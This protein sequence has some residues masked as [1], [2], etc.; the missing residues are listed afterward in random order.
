M[1]PAASTS[2][3]GPPG[4]AREG[5]PFRRPARTT[6]PL[7]V[8]TMSWSALARNRLDA[9]QAIVGTIAKHAGMPGQGQL[10]PIQDIADG[11][12]GREYSAAPEKWPL[13]QSTEGESVHLVA[14]SWPYPCTWSSRGQVQLI[15]GE[16]SDIALGR[17]HA[18]GAFQGGQGFR[19]F[20]A[21]RRTG[22]TPCPAAPPG[23][24]ERAEGG[25]TAGRPGP[26]RPPG[27]G[28]SNV[29]RT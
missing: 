29:G 16:T 20:V 1:P 3:G 5:R 10:E 9:E 17:S 28:D 18:T 12:A 22:L 7:R 6:I 13:P 23:R 4:F 19:T 26:R 11:G 24:E 8:C 2:R 15:R 27:P 14:F 21:A 25:G